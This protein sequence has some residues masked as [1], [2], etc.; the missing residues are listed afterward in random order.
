MRTSSLI[1]TVAAVTLGVPAFSRPNAGRATPSA[2]SP[3]VV[4]LDQ[5][6]AWTA[7]RRAAFYETGQ[8]SEI[9]PMAWA[10]ALTTGS[11]APLLGDHLARYGYLVNHSTAELP[12]GF[13]SDTRGGTAYLGMTRAACH[14]REISV[15]NA[16]YRVDGGPALS[17]FQ[18]FLSDLDGAVGRVLA[19]DATFQSF[20]ERVLG[21]NATADTRIALKR[22]VTAWYGRQ[23]RIVLARTTTGAVGRWPAGRGEHDP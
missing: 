10:R 4:F 23:P 17:D 21:A 18:H 5:G 15:G 7:A 3:D 1:L 2:S 13:T 8:G 16:V 9:M 20:A 19:D 11:G 12:V 14:T 22:E 6:P